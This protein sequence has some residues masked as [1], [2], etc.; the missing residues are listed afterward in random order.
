MVKESTISVAGDFNHI[1]DPLNSIRLRLLSCK[2][3]INTRQSPIPELGDYTPHKTLI[4]ASFIEERESPIPAQHS[5]D[6]LMSVIDLS[7]GRERPF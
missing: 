1:I 7:V 2:R 6:T 4:K 3:K 5:L